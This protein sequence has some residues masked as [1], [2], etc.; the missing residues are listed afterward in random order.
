MSTID[1]VSEIKSRLP[2]PEYLRQIGLLPSKRTGQSWMLKCVFHA[3]KTASLSVSDQFY[4]CFGCHAAGDVFSWVMHHEGLSFAEAKASLAL[5]IGIALPEVPSARRV[6]PEKRDRLFACNA[7]ASDWFRTQLHETP[8]ALEYLHG[9]SLTPETIDAWSLGYAP[10][11]FHGLEQYLKRRG[12]EVEAR[13]L[14]LITPDSRGRADRDFFVDRIMFPVRT[15]DGRIAGFSGRLLKPNEKVKPY[16]NSKDSPIFKKSDLLLG[17]DRARKAAWQ[18]KRIY[19]VEGNVDVV[20][21][22]QA[23]ICNVVAPCGTALT[24]S[25]AALLCRTA[26]EVVIVTDGDAP[27]RAAAPGQAKTVLSQDTC[28][29][30]LV[31]E[32]PDGMDPAELYVAEG[33]AGV[34]RVLDNAGD[35]LAAIVRH[36][37]TGQGDDPQ[38]KLATVRLLQPWL[39]A[40]AGSR[41]D[42]FIDGA[43][44]IL[45]IEPELMRG[46]MGTLDASLT[47]DGRVRIEVHRGKLH[48]T[49]EQI[50]AVLA[51]YATNV[52]RR[53][54][55]PVEVFLDEGT[56]RFAT[57]SS[58]FYSS[59]VS[60][61]CHFERFDGLDENDQ[62]EWVTIDPP[63]PAVTAHHT[64][65]ANS[66]RPL[67]GVADTPIVR[68]DGAIVSTPGYD[69]ATRYLYAPS[70]PIPDV[71]LLPTRAQAEAA[72]AELLDLVSTFTVL[73]DV[74]TSAILA[75]IITPLVRSACDIVPLFWCDGHTSES[76]KGEIPRIASVLRT[77]AN[78]AETTY[79]LDDERNRRDLLAR[80]YGGDPVVI[81]DN[82]PNGGQV[83]STWLC[84]WVTATDLSMRT[85]YE[86]N[87]TKFPHSSTYYLSGNNCR[88]KE[89]LSTR[90]VRA[91]LDGLP[92]PAKG[93]PSARARERRGHY[94]NCVLTLIRAWMTSGDTVEL[95]FRTRF[96]DWDRMVR[97]ALIWIGLADP[98]GN[99][100]SIKDSD[101]PRRARG[102]FIRAWHAVYG[103][104]HVR[105]SEA[106][107]R[108]L[109]PTMDTE[110]EMRSAFEAIFGA[111]A[112]NNSNVGTLIES[113]AGQNHRGLR[114]LKTSNDAGQRLVFVTKA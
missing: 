50:D 114:F 31:A 82:L 88:L 6:A 22:H 113:M 98:L 47:P 27:G 83:G 104:K 84:T 105:V 37:A 75:A 17:I 76:G 85:M 35:A 25:Q 70:C 59:L 87:D 90:C 57:I 14:Q 63:R 13:E 43:A 67:I 39:V 3:E 20:A 81:W 42:L 51:A 77:G 65:N 102:D 5:R 52:Y 33:E 15:P 32:M 34:R 86:D 93:A 80:A 73:E 92:N 12:F 53:G 111:K 91:R 41:K 19:V 64:A 18:E 99:I 96:S 36:A 54:R 40:L 66:L 74:D 9:R 100:E 101:A 103:N 68:R 16:I 69:P 109:T 55:Q 1:I 48:K 49:V 24:D 71:P 23:G 30:A 106:V 72:T 78:A 60:R 79:S 58:E 89:D 112:P 11:N 21:L 108:M 45:D 94:V 38:G 8:A 10:H 7:T 95:K 61:F 46:W 29:R 56:Y 97:S 2:L 44:R 110:R 62:P 28:E 4:N 107:S 26:T